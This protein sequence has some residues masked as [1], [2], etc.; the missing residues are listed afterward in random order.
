MKQNDSGI[1]ILDEFEKVLNNAEVLDTFLEMFDK[2]TVTDR[3]GIKYNCRPFIFILTSNLGK[4]LDSNCSEEE[5]TTLL[6]ESNKVRPEF[7]GRISLIEVFNH[8]S[9]ESAKIL[10]N[11]F[12]E[13][14]NLLPDFEAKFNFDESA[15]KHILKSADFNTYGAR[16]LKRVFSE[17][18]HDILLKNL[19]KL[20]SNKTYSLV[21]ENNNYIIK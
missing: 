3:S 17:H 13:E 6:K 18:M 19:D 16:N 4:D 8:I 2:G 12:L 5:K 1:I 9:E 20:Q 10:L 11:K 15:L 21:Y 7:I 14:Y